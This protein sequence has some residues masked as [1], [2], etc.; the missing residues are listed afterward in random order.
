MNSLNATWPKRYLLWLD[1]QYPLTTREAYATDLEQF[2][3]HLAHKG[4]SPDS[5]E[6]ITQVHIEAFIASLFRE[7]TSKRSIA[8]KLAS[9][10]SYFRYLLRHKAI[11]DNPAQDIRNPKQEKKE[12]HVPNVDS[13]FTLLDAHASAQPHSLRDKA[14]LELLYGSGLRISEALS[15]NVSDVV[16]RQ[17]LKVKGKGSRERL[18][19]LSDTSVERI[20][21]W[22]AVRGT[23]ADAQEEALF[24]GTRGKR[25][26]RKEA[27]RICQEQAKSTGI[28]QHISPHTMR[29][30]FATHLLE[31]GMDLRSV[32]EL[33][34][35][36]RL[37][38]TQQYTHVSMRELIAVYDQAHPRGDEHH[39]S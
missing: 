13:V 24:V 19:P 12:A 9:I 1:S 20:N 6:T 23:I 3:N 7:G 28:E 32:Q 37:S 38:T 14:L 5:P 26:N 36:R 15:L 21:K 2:L 16:G 29:H 34:G 27:W 35:H 25:L 17:V 30:A 31:N 18:V 4:I 11:A 8:R 39:D 33:L 22:L 10:R